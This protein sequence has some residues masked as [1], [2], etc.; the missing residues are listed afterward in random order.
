MFGIICLL[1]EDT[2]KLDS[3]AHA[4]LRLFP[5]YLTIVCLNLTIK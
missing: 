3:R 2:I 5:F 1:T 4:R